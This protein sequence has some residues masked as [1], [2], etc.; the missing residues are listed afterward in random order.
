MKDFHWRYGQVQQQSREEVII[1]QCQGSGSRRK[2]SKEG[3]THRTGDKFTGKDQGMQIN[4][5]TNFSQRKVSVLIHAL[6]ISG[7]GGFQ[8]WMMG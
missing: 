6:G 5:D 7:K 2:S 8:D 3:R 1:E 4:L